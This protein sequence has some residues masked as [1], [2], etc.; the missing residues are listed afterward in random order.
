MH[1][2]SDSDAPVSCLLLTGTAG[3]GK[4]V[5]A[6]EVGEVLRLRTTGF[7]VIDLDSIAKCTTEPPVPGR[8]ESELMIANLVS[9]WPNYRRYGVTRLITARAVVD[10]D[11]FDAMRVAIPN[12]VWTVCRLVAP[13][14]V[15]TERIRARE[16]GIAQAF[17]VGLAAPMAQEMAA[18]AI[19]DFTVENGRDR[20]V[21]DVAEE[22]IRRWDARSWA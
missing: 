8:F 19:D 15:V 13:P 1:P 3:A 21:T 4:S 17:L 16:H 18:S 22:V 2:L 5:V 20:S 6:K 10:R 11:E 9:I 14:S 7:A 12:S